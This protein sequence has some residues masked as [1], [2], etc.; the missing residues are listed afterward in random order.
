MRWR[1]WRVG[2]YCGDGGFGDGA[3][4]EMGEDEEEEIESE[5][6]ALEIAAKDA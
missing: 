5:G 2:E 4:V 3:R 6:E 1:W